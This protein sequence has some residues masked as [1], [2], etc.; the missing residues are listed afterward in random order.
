MDLSSWPRSWY[1]SG[2]LVEENTEKDEEENRG[3]GFLVNMIRASVLTNP[4]PFMEAACS[5]AAASFVPLRPLR[6]KIV[7]KSVAAPNRLAEFPLT[8]ENVELVLD[9]VRSYLISDGGN[10]VIHEIDG[11]VVS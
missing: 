1:L 3:V 11:N 7:V 4:S 10:V 9:E 2:R 8:A 5:F 6:L